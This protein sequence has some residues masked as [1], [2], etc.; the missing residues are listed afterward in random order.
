MVYRQKEKASKC[1][2]YDFYSKSIQ[3]MLQHVQAT[4]LHNYKIQLVSNNIHID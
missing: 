1:V 2:Q 4:L 3:Q